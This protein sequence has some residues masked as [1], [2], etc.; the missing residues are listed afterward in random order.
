MGH[1]HHGHPLHHDHD[2]H[3]VDLPPA[4]DTAVPDDEL[5]PAELRRAGLLGAGLGAAGVAARTSARP[6]SRMRA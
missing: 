5:N 6:T 3:A 1:H 4:L 2:N